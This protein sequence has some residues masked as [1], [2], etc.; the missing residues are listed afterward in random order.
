MTEI[1][2]PSYAKINLTLEVGPKRADG[3]HFLD[4][5]VRI[6]DLRDTRT[7][8]MSETLTVTCY[9]P[10]VPCDERNTA[11]KAA[12]IFFERTG[13][14][15][16]AAIHIE[17]RIPSQAGLGGGS[18]NAAAV[19]SALNDMY[20][21]NLTTDD[22]SR[23][24]AEVGSDVPLF[25]KGPLLRMRGRGEITENLPYDLPMWLVII[26]PKAGV[27]TA[28]AYRN[29]DKRA[30]VPEFNISEKMIDALATGGDVW[31]YVSNDFESV[32]DLP[33]IGEAKNL[34]A[35]AKAV[36]MSGSGSAVYGVYDADEAQKVYERIK[37]GRE[38]YLCGGYEAD[39]E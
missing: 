9:D 2:V 33:E 39:N 16:G 37:D 19:L 17:K 38:C 32:C 29:L 24:G 14:K 5:V 12:K 35:G 23:M 26:K 36:C 15:S 3:Y 34:L 27:S 30:R 8:R 4:S 28:D 10:E 6:I 11:Y 22:L 20:E 13:I 31:K 21:A 18:G 1:S 25:F 7:L